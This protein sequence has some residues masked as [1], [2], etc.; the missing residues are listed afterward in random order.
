MSVISINCPERKVHST[1]DKFLYKYMDLQFAINLL[2]DE[3]LYFSAPTNWKDPYEQKVINGCF[4]I[5]SSKHSI[6]YPLKDRIFACCFTELYSCEAQWKMYKSSKKNEPTVEIQFNKEKLLKA[7]ELTDRVAFIGKVKYYNTGDFS[8][9]VANCFRSKAAIKSLTKKDPRSTDD[10]KC[11]LKP[12]FIKRR[13]FEY[14][15]EWRIIITDED[16]YCNDS[17]STYPKVD[18]PGLVDCVERIIIAPVTDKNDSAVDDIKKTLSKYIDPKKISVSS[19][20]K[21]SKRTSIFNISPKSG[22]EK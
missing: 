1:N 19:L 11:I 10:I 5:D 20:Y 21:G 12:M 8:E 22:V 16:V 4:H 2:K 17:F 9:A 13:G 15:Q 6:K 18:I 14:E 3:E 7:I